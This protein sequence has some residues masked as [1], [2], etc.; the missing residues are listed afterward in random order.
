MLSLISESASWR[1]WPRIA[2][3]GTGLTKLTQKWIL[4]L[5][6]PWSGFPGASVVKNLSAVQEPQETQVRSLG[7]EDPLK[8]GMA[9]HCSILAWRIPWTEEP[10]RL[11]CTVHR[12]V[13]SWTRLMWLGTLTCT[14]GHC[15]DINTVVGG[16]LEIHFP[17][18]WTRIGYWWRGTE[19]RLGLGSGLWDIQGK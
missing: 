8:E 9:T 11:Q 13:K 2:G 1:N 10:G 7:Q 18:W 19:G 15:N 16:C 12:V 5:D 6:Y 3:S 14:H 17:S 4:E